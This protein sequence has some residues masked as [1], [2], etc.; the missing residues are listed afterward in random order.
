MNGCGG[1]GVVDAGS[2]ADRSR[3][4]RPPAADA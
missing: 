4:A 3:G 1:A 2:A